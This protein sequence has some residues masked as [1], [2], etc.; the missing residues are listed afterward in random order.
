[1]AKPG[2]PGTGDTIRAAAAF[3]VDVRPDRHR[4][5][6][7]PHGELDMATVDRVATTVD[8]LVRS[9]FDTLVLDLRATSFMDSSGLHLV[10]AQTARDDAQ[11]TVI[12]GVECVSK[13]FDLAGVRQVVPFEAAP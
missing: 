9:G 13:L 12:D 10:L 2:L 6:V 8:E 4:V 5:F 3:H 7:V 11:I 1:M